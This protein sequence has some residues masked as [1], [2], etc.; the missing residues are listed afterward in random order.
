LGAL[1]SAA[2]C[3]RKELISGWKSP[4]SIGLGCRERDCG[5]AM[6]LSS[7]IAY[8]L[9]SVVTRAAGV[10]A[11]GARL[12]EVRSGVGSVIIIEGRA[13]RVRARQEALHRVIEPVFRESLAF[14]DRGCGLPDHVRRDEHRVEVTGRPGGVIRDCQGG[15]FEEQEFDSRVAR[16]ASSAGRSSQSARMS[17]RPR[18]ALMRGRAPHR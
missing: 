7:R 11:I 10:A 2:R 9:S 14:R 13:V 17:S 1:P 15:A 8:H 4:A 16:A 12:D 6:M 3:S 18:P 5:V